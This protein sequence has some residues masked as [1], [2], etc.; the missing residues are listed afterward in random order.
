MIT[1]EHLGAITSCDAPYSMTPFLVNMIGS[2]MRLYTTLT[3]LGGN[4]VLLAGFVLSVLTNAI[5][6]WQC[7][8]YRPRLTAGPSAQQ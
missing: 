4:K 5:L 6:V 2:L 7:I 3:Q 8:R 1:N